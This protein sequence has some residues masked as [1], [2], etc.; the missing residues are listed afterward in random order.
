M[1]VKFL[2]NISN[3]LTRQHGVTINKTTILFFAAVKTANLE[4]KFI[5]ELNYEPRYEDV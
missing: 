2:P 4:V 1:A 5:S 3:P